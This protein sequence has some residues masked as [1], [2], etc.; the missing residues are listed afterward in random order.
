MRQCES[1]WPEENR[2]KCF[3]TAALAGGAAEGRGSRRFSGA[4]YGFARARWRAQAERRAR[5]P[6]CEGDTRWCKA[7]RLLVR[8][9]HSLVGCAR[10][11]GAGAD[12]RWCKVEAC[13]CE[14]RHSVGR[15]DVAG[16]VAGSA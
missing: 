7:R 12:V 13:W 5:A 2:G 6:E 16:F 11:T 4:P 10:L 15:V 9:R 14:G 3:G 1:V 8:G